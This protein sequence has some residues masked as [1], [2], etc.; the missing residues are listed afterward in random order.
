MYRESF[1]AYEQHLPNHR[2]RGR[3][4]VVVGRRQ[5][6]ALNG[7]LEL[8]WKSSPA[9]LCFLSGEHL[10]DLCDQPFRRKWFQKKSIDRPQVSLNLKRGFLH[11]G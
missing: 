7:V 6:Q 8:S 4:G 5:R 3:G 1:P 2:P 11:K 10:L 9:P